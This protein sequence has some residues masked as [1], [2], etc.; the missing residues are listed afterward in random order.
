MRLCTHDFMYASSEQGPLL[1][2]TLP[3]VLKY[4][5]ILSSGTYL[6]DLSRVLLVFWWPIFF[7]LTDVLF[8]RNGFIT[9]LVFGA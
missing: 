6:N 1:A 3:Q 2:L 4:V 8:V 5:L 9:I 7:M